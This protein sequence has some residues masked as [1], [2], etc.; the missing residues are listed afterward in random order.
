MAF[1][2]L[3]RTSQQIRARS[4]RIARNQSPHLFS[5]ASKK[6]KGLPTELPLPSPLQ[7]P[8]QSGS[9][10]GKP[11]SA[12]WR[13]APWWLPARG[14]RSTGQRQL[15]EA[16]AGG[17]PKIPRARSIPRA[18]KPPRRRAAPSAAPRSHQAAPLPLR[19]VASAAALL[20][21]SNGEE[22]ETSLVNSS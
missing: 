3:A 15:G 13:G 7:D 4:L 20:R 8:R 22:M 12:G 1:V 14:S 21:L 11:R 5:S 19:A 6:K 2:P 9:Q 17:R 16:A 10:R 18:L